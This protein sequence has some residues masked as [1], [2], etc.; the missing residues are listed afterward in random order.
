MQAWGIFHAQSPLII[1]NGDSKILVHD[2]IILLM[3]M[4]Q[5]AFLKILFLK[6]LQHT[7]YIIISI[8]VEYNTCYVTICLK[9]IQSLL[10]SNDLSARVHYY[11]I[12]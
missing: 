12:R 5:V 10:Q 11:I 3:H 4:A 6:K 1:N 8:L 2:F 9:Q 7:C